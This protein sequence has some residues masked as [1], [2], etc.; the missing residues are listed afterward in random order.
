M[1]TA[2]MIRRENFLA[3]LSRYATNREFADRCELPPAFVS[4]IKTARRNIGDALARD[5]ERALSLPKA[6]MDVLHDASANG[7]IAREPEVALSPSGQTLTR[8]TEKKAHY[9]RISTPQVALELAD[10]ILRASAE[11]RIDDRVLGSLLQLVLAL[12]SQPASE[13]G[14]ISSAEG[15]SNDLD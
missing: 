3:L 4:Q 2:H 12:A 8:V 7:H 5:I 15:G 11:R 6:W 1:K 10:E 13:Q 14:K 9:P